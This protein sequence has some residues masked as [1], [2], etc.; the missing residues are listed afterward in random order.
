MCHG[1]DPALDLRRYVEGLCSKL[2]KLWQS[3]GHD[4]AGKLK[5]LRWLRKDALSTWGTNILP[6]FGPAKWSRKAGLTL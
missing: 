2:A 6:I 1:N 3:L 4:I 5:V